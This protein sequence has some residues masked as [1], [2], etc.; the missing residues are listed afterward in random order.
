MDKKEI[1]AAK[2]A[3]WGLKLSNSE[4]EQLVPAYENLLRWQAVL[5]EMLRSRQ[6]ADGM[7]Y[8]ESEP[9][10]IHAIERKGSPQ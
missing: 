9:L 8:P 7:S 4:L 10:L 1:V 6:I 3:E 2:L 5:E